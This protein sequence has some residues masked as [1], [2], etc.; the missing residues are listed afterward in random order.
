MFGKAKP[1][2]HS[3]WWYVCT[4]TGELHGTVLGEWMVVAGQPH[5]GK[6]RLL[7]PH[8]LEMSC[9]IRVVLCLPFS[10][11]FGVL[12]PD[13]C[14]ELAV[15]WSLYLFWQ[16]QTGL[17]GV[18]LHFHPPHTVFSSYFF[19]VSFFT[20]INLDGKHLRTRNCQFFKRQNSICISSADK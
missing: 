13:T 15:L 2:L 8:P 20:Y 9:R 14:Q 3:R 10:N 18:G 11:T 17:V 1:R 19:F 5:Q 12:L 4:Y 16:I 6:C 7:Y